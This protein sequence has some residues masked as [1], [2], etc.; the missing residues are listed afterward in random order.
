MP[1][2]GRLHKLITQAAAD[3]CIESFLS[4][5]HAP[6]LR[7]QGRILLAPSRKDKVLVEHC[8]IPAALDHHEAARSRA[9]HTT[10]EGA[11]AP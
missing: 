2:A 7:H 1:L 9:G 11:A 5:L 4:L 6:H 8:T 10:S 3:E